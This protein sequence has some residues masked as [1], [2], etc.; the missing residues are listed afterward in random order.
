MAAKNS[1]TRSAQRRSSPELKEKI[2]EL[3]ASGVSVRKISA[4]DGMP[5]FVS[6]QRWQLD[7][8]EFASKCAQARAQAQD[9]AVEEIQ[10]LA[11][12]V[13]E[14]G[15][16]GKMDAAF[17]AWKRNQISARQWIASKLAPKKYGDKLDVDVQGNLTVNISAKDSTVL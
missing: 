1:A 2:V 17:V 15:A 5:H 16:D 4:M 9:L 6:I 12:E 7:D 8:A 13:P 3:I 14:R 10:A 11:D